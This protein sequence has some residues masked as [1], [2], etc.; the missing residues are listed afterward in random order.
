[1]KRWIFLLCALIFFSLCAVSCASPGGELQKRPGTV[2]HNRVIG[3]EG[4]EDEAPS[5]PPTSSAEPTPPPAT[6]T[7]AVS[8]PDTTQQSGTA[9]DEQD[10]GFRLRLEWT[11]SSSG[12]RVTVETDLFLDCYSLTVNSSKSGFI[13]VNGQKHSFSTETIQE[14][15][16]QFHSIPVC[17]KSFSFSSEEIP[18]EGIAVEAVWNFNG[19]YGGQSIEALSLHETIELGRTI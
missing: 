9:R 1:M 16:N 13:T 6:S 12:D 10:A 2:E 3:A 7:A 15:E 14:T 18:P 8:V 11:A 5:V 4:E 17:K 19:S